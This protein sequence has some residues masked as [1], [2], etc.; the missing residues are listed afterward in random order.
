[1]LTGAVP[2]K[3]KTGI[4]IY[5]GGNTEYITKKESSLSRVNYLSKNVI[6]LTRNFSILDNR[7]K[8]SLENL[9]VSDY[10]IYIS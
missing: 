2:E 8:L 1:M 6:F 3:G 4:A 5:N 7:R 10:N 9:F